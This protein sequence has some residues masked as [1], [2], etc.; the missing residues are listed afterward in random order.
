MLKNKGLYNLSYSKTSPHKAAHLFSF[1]K[2]F[3][4][5]K[6]RQISIDPVS[7]SESTFKTCLV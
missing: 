7:T 6:L 3:L 4:D 5:E 1:N 2:L